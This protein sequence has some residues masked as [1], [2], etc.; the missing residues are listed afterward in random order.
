MYQLRETLCDKIDS[1]NIPYSDEEKLFENMVKLKI[2]NICMLEDKFRDTNT[3]TRLGKHVPIS[4]SIPTNLIKQPIFLCNFNLGAL[5]EAFVDTFGGLATLEQTQ[6][7]LEFLE[8]ETSVN[9][10]LNQNGNFRGVCMEDIAAVEDVVQAIV[11]L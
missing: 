4:V 2:E 6:T 5:V 3:T 8:F 7:K 10:E 1:F 9:S 11:I